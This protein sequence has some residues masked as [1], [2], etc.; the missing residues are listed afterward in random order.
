MKE[1][2]ACMCPHISS[3][4]SI[5]CTVSMTSAYL[6][7]CRWYYNTVVQCA[8]VRMK[9][10]SKPINPC[11]L[12]STVSKRYITAVFRIFTSIIPNRVLLHRVMHAS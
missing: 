9:I 8:C 1:S 3:T 7:I 12:L 4:E 6:K 11:T 10:N 2:S 5:E